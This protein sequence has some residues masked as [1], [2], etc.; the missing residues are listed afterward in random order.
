MC[1]DDDYDA[2]FDECAE[3]NPAYKCNTNGHCDGFFPPGSFTCKCDYGY[4]LDLFAC[5]R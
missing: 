2:D 1:V 4:E 5:V 3:G